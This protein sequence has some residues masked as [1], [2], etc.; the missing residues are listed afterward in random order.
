MSKQCIYCGTDMDDDALFCGEC[1]KKQE[2][3]EKHP[4]VS[5]TILEKEP[6]N[7]IQPEFKRDKKA[8]RKQ[9][10]KHLAILSL[11]F[12][13]I[14]YPLS[15]TIL[16]PLVTVP[17][18]IIFGVKGLKSSKKKTSILGLI[19]NFSFVILIVVGILM[20]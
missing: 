13:I 20:L 9:D 2:S 8:E 4:T 17:L 19:L 11:I 12:G 5:Q 6:L 18:G 3:E 16:I 7:N 10:P 14:S 15:L 1:G